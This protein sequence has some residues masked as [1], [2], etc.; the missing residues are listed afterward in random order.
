MELLFF[1]SDF[2]FGRRTAGWDAKT[3]SRTLTTIAG[4]VHS[5]V[6]TYKPDNVFVLFLG[7]IMDG[8]AVYPEQAYEL[9]FSGSNR[10]MKALTYF[11]RIFSSHWRVFA[12]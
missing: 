2:H 5:L 6:Q 12:G 1:V 4:K 7:D 3:A 11:S 9:D 8:E 10:S